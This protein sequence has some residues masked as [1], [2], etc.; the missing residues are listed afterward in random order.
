[1][2]AFDAHLNRQTGERCGGG[3]VIAPYG[4]VSTCRMLVLI[5]AVL[6]NVERE[7]CM[8]GQAG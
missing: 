5:L 6:E 4:Q 3:G 2:I 1:M 7:G 8:E